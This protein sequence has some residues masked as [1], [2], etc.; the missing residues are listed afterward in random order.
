MPAYVK[1]ELRQRA[2][3]LLLVVQ[4]DGAGFDVAA[5]LGRAAHGASLGLLGLQ[6]RVLLVGGQV[7][8][9]FDSPASGTTITA[10]LPNT[11]NMPLERRRRGGAR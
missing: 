11:P 3:D 4:D 8:I 1:V 7:T 9:D 6:E 10:L 2:A 5:A